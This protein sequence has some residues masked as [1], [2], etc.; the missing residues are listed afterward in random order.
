M[1][2]T[3]ELNQFFRVT[4]FVM[5][6]KMALGNIADIN[7]NLYKLLINANIK[8]DIILLSTTRKRLST[9]IP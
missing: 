7:L 5:L 6:I 3:M 9:R 2:W 8:A 1:K 4:Q